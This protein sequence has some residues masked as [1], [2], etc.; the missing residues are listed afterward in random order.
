[1]DIKYSRG[2]LNNRKIKFILCPAYT[3]NG[4]GICSDENCICFH[5][6]KMCIHG[7]GCS[8]KLCNF[9]HPEG[10]YLRNESEQKTIKNRSIRKKVDENISINVL[11]EKNINDGFFL[12]FYIKDTKT[13]IEFLNRYLKMNKM[14]L[15]T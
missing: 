5:P 11:E 1:M 9:I 8:R 4:S 12:A 14:K 6:R 2:G 15:I 3:K 13:D 7:I 10:Y